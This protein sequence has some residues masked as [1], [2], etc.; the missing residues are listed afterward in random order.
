MAQPPIDSMHLSIHDIETVL[1]HAEHSPTTIS[2][3]FAKLLEQNHHPGLVQA[4]CVRIAPLSPI[5]VS[6]H[7]AIGGHKKED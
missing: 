7:G 2:A 5:R 4:Y 3:V 1:N 6:Y